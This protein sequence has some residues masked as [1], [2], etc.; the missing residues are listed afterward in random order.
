MTD[1]QELEIER[2]VTE[3]RIP[4]VPNDPTAR[5][6]F[7]HS[8]VIGAVNEGASTSGLNRFQAGGKSPLEVLEDSDSDGAVEFPDDQEEEE[9][10]DNDVSR[11]Y[12]IVKVT[13]KIC[14]KVP[15]YF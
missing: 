1:S 10:F 5:D 14:K 2:L 12:S 6:S 9:E 15:S 4:E 3:G 8:R 13:E 11:F 7:V